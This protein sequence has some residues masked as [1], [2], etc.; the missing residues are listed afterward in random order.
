VKRDPE[1]IE[2]AKKSKSKNALRAK[3]IEKYPE[4]HIEP[5]FE[6]RFYFT[7][8]QKA[9]LDEAVAK[10]RENDP[11]IKTL[12]GAIEQIVADWMDDRYY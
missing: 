10:I 5:E 1:I 12:E 6:V 7:E 3:I 9:K 11:E 8:S 2:A 4:Q